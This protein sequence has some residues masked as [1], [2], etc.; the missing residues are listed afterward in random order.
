MQRIY[1]RR[2]PYAIAEVSSS[3]IRKRMSVDPPWDLYRSLHAVLREG[4]LSGA[5]RALGLSQPTIGRHVD[6]LEAALGRRLFLRSQRGLVATE[7]ARQ[8]LPYLEAL[9]ATSAALRRAVAATEGSVGGTV[10]ITASE[11][12]GVER[13][14]P[15]LAALRRRHPGLELSNAVEDLLR[16]D[17]DIAVRMVA[18]VQEALVARK[19]GTAE[20]GLYAHAGYLAGR[21][22]P[23]RVG[24][25]AAHDLIGFDRETPALRAF[26]AGY[27]W[28]AAANF[29]FRAGSDLAQLAAVRAGVGI[30]VCQV[31]I[32]ARDPALV[33]VLPA[34]FAPGLP[35]WVVMH[36]D[37][38][39]TPRVR[40]AFDLLAEHLARQLA[41]D[42]LAG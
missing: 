39:T 28:L 20:L 32:A 11:I 34:D 38:R 30:G 15:I 3:A 33:R 25:L 16:R 29:A 14:P 17:A 12:V 8:M 23:A 40:A 10:R 7:A 27:P 13:L 31:G 42:A 9:A 5:A 19:V 24:D 2:I 4:S 26:L 18:P 37:L 22:P 21:T 1:R 6:A 41:D 36:E 35:T